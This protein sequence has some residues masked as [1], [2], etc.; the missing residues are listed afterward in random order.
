[1]LGYDT[2]RRFETA[3]ERAKITCA[4]VDEEIADHFAG[5]VEIANI[6]G[7]NQRDLDDCALSRFGC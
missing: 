1:L 7:G 5:A 3:I 2:W 4:N 6:G